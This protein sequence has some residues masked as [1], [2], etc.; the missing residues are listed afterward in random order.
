M[1]EAVSIFE[2]NRNLTQDYLETLMKAGKFEE[3][4][5]AFDEISNDL[6]K[7]GKLQYCKAFA[8][9]KLEKY[10][11][12]AEIVNDKFQMDDIK[13]GDISIADLWYELYA[14]VLKKAGKL[15]EG[16]DVET[17][18]EQYYPLGDLDFRMHTK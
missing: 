12:A 6:K 1:K 8:L 15:N 2:G 4:V 7:I 10:D 11:E 18:V 14:G 3:C 9:T 5:K 13:E 16:D 17:V